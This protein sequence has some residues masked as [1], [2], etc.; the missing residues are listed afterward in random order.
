MGKTKNRN[1][2]ETEYLKG[3][4]RQLQSQL[5][6]YKQ[7]ENYLEGPIE[8]VEEVQ[9]IEADQ[10][11]RCSHGVLITYDF[12]RAVL[13]KCDCGYEERKAKN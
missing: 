11:P 9:E 2:S 12:F 10:C 6:Y 8:Q 3:I 1:R 7:R 5:K 13:K 4:I